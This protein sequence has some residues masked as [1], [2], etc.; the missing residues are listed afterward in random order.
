MIAR[1]YSFG[2]RAHTA[3]GCIYL[4][5]QRGG[6]ILSSTTQQGVQGGPLFGDVNF[7]ARDQPLVGSC[8]IRSVCRSTQGFKRL[9]VNQLLRCIQC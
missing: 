3:E 8:E 5:R 4:I 6:C 2:D 9:V 1:M 7:S